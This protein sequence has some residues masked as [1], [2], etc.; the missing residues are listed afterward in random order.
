[1][2]TEHEGPVVDPQPQPGAGGNGQRPPNVPPVSL[3]FPA[4]AS[5]GSG[6][7]GEWLWN[8]ASRLWGFF[9]GF[10][11]ASL[12]FLA[13]SL[14]WAYVNAGALRIL[15]FDGTDGTAQALKFGDALDA[16]ATGAQAGLQLDLSLRQSSTSAMPAISVPGV[17]ISFAALV[18]FWQG[19]F[20][21]TRVKGA[22]IQQGPPGASTYRVWLHIEGPKIGTRVVATEPAVNL[23]DALN[24]GAESAYRVLRPVVAAYYL[25][26][27][28]PAQSLQVVDEILSDPKRGREDK[29][30]AYRIWG[31]VLRDQGDHEGAVAQFQQAAALTR[32]QGFKA[33]VLVDEGYALLWTGSS[34]EAAEVFH[35]AATADPE[36]TV[37]RGLWA[38]ALREGSDFDAAALHY[39]EAIDADPHASQPWLGLARLQAA[40]RDYAA[41]IDSYA[42]ARTLSLATS[43]RASISSEFGG[44]LLGLGSPDGAIAL[45]D[46]AVLDD[47]GLGASRPDWVR[48]LACQAARPVSGSARACTATEFTG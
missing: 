47:P 37:P 39:R 14:L 12:G 1:M 44:F 33:R 4:P 19:L 48:V 35:A 28:Y 32:D 36:W 46:R 6:G 34:H 2:P 15:P 25:Y 24:A 13:G 41:A 3:S 40:Q 42:K 17:N 8:N 22:V 5:G 27:R 16:V 7:L 9:P 11:T 45:Y 30:A 21:D 20:G 26:R 23:E 43:Q 31:L 10:G 38:D 18:D 29:A